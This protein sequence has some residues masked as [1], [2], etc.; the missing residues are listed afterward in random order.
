MG[1]FPLQ[2]CERRSPSIKPEMHHIAT[3]GTAGAAIDLIRKS[4]EEVLA[5]DFVIDLPNLGGASKIARKR[6][7]N[8]Y[9]CGI[10]RSLKS[11]YRNCT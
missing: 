7:E 5:A 1:P 2:L 3:G 6:S 8:P 11:F 9:T 10:F 4:G